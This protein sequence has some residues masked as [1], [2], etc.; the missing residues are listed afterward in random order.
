MLRFR[1]S[2][3]NN[4]WIKE[5][6]IANSVNDLKTSQRVYPNF[7]TLDARIASALKT[8]IQIWNCKSKAHTEEQKAQKEDRFLPSREIANTIHEYFWMTATHESI[9]DFFALMRLTLRT[10]RPCLRFRHEM[11]RYPT[12]DRRR[13]VGQNSGTLVQNAD[14]R[15]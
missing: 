14:T 11:G 13:S 7:E 15:V 4:A 12:F 3:G 6:E 9:L 10:W 5:V 2:K 8:I 1:S